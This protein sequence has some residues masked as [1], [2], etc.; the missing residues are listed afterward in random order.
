MELSSRNRV[1]SS[2]C[3]YFNIDTNSILTYD[4]RLHEDSR[5]RASMNIVLLDCLL[6]LSIVACLVIYIS[7]SVRS[8]IFPDSIVCLEK[9]YDKKIE[10]ISKLEILNQIKVK[11]RK[12]FKL[13]KETILY[14]Y[15]N[16]KDIA[17][18]TVDVND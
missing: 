10:N 6:A 17:Y 5:G 7:L 4:V 12:L 14:F 11:N 9:F 18:V 15:L 2:L 16:Y 1:D 13:T 3:N 8:F